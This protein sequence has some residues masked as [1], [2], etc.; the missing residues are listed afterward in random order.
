MKKTFY[1]ISTTRAEYGL[2]KN[3]YIEK[4]KFKNIELKLVISGTHLSGYFGK[5]VEE[6]KKD[7]IKIFKAIKLDHDFQ[8]PEKIFAKTLIKFSN[9]FKLNRPEAVVLLGDRYETLSVALACVFNKISIC[10]IQGGEIT[11]GSIDN[12]FRNCITKISDYHFSA[13]KLARKRIIGMG[14]APQN[15]FTVGSLFLDNLRKKNF[16]SKKQLE[17]RFRFKFLKK[18][19][20]VTLHPE[21][22]GIINPKR[23]INILL[24]SIKNFKDIFFIFTYPNQDRGHQLIIKEIKTFVKKN[25]NS[26][27]IKSFGQKFFH[28]C[29]KHVDCIVGNSSSGVIEAP[30]FKKYTINIGNRQEGRL[31]PKSVICTAYKKKSIA[32]VVKDIYR[33]KDNLPKHKNENLYGSSGA[34]KK[35]LMILSHKVINN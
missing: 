33:S 18:N 11:K 26:I 25:R 22:K 28:S 16:L 19:M 13:H 17:K 6:I 1:I 4:K 31:M 21:T 8:N 5:T 32:K 2:I 30:Y 7:R 3:I 23:Q 27:L 12:V 20:L 24:S 9:F 35:I 34:A 10:H 29:L 14:E 15:T